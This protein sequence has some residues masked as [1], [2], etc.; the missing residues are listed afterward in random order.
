MQSTLASSRAS[1]SAVAFRGAPTSRAAAVVPRAAAAARRSSS[2]RELPA[3]PLTRLASS[4]VVV[5]ATPSAPTIA[6]LDS[7]APTPK[8]G[9]KVRMDR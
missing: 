1:S 6:P 7:I 2:A 3:F 4:S 9:E 8:K 5:R